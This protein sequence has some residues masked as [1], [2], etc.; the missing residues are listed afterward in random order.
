MMVSWVAGLWLAWSGFGFM[1]TWLYL[2]LAAVIAMSAV[3]GIFP[4][5]CD[6]LPKTGMKP[7]R[8]IGA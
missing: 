6:D 2:K 3:H 7:H 1:G 4:V 8:V 5:P